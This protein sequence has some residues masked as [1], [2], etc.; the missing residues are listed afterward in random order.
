M[1]SVYVKVEQLI[2]KKQTRENGAR[3]KYKRLKN[4]HGSKSLA[5]KYNEFT[6][7]ILSGSVWGREED[8]AS[9]FPEAEFLDEIQKKV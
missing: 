4:K 5:M 8:P 1:Y 6:V 7:C 2:E 3:K 9:S